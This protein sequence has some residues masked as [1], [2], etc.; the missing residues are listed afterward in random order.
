MQT[1]WGSPPGK[2]E[3]WTAWPS[4]GPYPLARRSVFP[5]RKRGQ[6]GLKRS[7]MNSTRR[8]WRIF[9]IPFW[10]LGW[11]SMRSNPGI[12]SGPCAWMNW[13]FPCGCSENTIQP[14]ISMPS[15]PGRR[16]YIPWSAPPVS[17][18]AW[19]SELKQCQG[20]KDKDIMPHAQKL[21]V[22]VNR[23]R[24]EMKGSLIESY[25]Q[26]LRQFELHTREDVV[27]VLP[28]CH[29]LWSWNPSHAD[30]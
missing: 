23:M 15:G 3:N 13:R 25:V 6:I 16:F 21:E 28:F 18:P 12:R 9:L 17:T 24:E 8:S 29:I 14:W 22:L 20:L 27:I 2:S 19:T 10:W 4:A 11:R 30:F 1:G 26:T 5:C 7:G